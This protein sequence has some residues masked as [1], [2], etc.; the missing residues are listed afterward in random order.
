MMGTVPEIIQVPTRTPTAMRIRMATSIE[1]MVALISACRSSYLM[2]KQQAMTHITTP[3]VSR[4]TW[5][6]A[7][8][9]IRPR[10]MMAMPTTIISKACQGL[11]ILRCVVSLMYVP[12]LSPAPGRGWPLP[13]GPFT[14]ILRLYCR[15]PR[16]CLAGVWAAAVSLS[17]LPPAHLLSHLTLRCLPLGKP[18][19]TGRRPTRRR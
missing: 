4:I 10:K 12:P 9:T 19:R 17:L 14:R 18:S 16:L 8:N 13:W 6:L 15:I 3:S 1:L 2:P 5:F 11:T 7:L